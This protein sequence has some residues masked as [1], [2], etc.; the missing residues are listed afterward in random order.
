MERLG[1]ERTTTGCWAATPAVQRSRYLLSTGS[2][3][4]ASLVQQV[5]AISALCRAK[6]L[7]PDKR[8]LHPD[9]KE[10]QQGVTAQFQALQEA[11]ETLLDKV[12]WREGQQ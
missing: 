3:D 9:Q 4:A 5:Q 12:G 8:E 1:T 11:K 7:H 2:G 6:K 10:D